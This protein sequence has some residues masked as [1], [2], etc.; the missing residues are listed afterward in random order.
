MRKCL[1]LFNGPLAAMR[2]TSYRIDNQAADV[3]MLTCLLD[4]PKAG[5]EGRPSLRDSAPDQARWGVG[6]RLRR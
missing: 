1:R 2:M 3:S 6:L 5:R 4:Q